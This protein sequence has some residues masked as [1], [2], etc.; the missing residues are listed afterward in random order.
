MNKLIALTLIA[1]AAPAFTADNSELLSAQT[2]FRQALSAQTS[3]GSK[4]AS[5]QSDLASAQNRL[6]Q[7]QADVS[8]LTAELQT[9]TAEKAQNDSALQA[10]G[11]RLNEAWTATYGG[12]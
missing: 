7:A 3:N 4:I 9:A 11:Q 2:A 6:Q 10:A 8:R 1:A 12:Q 5:L